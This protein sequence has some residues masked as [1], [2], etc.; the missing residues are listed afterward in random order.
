M[1]NLISVRS[2]EDSLINLSIIYIRS[3]SMRL[4]LRSFYLLSRRN[5]PIINM[6]M[7]D[8][9][10]L[11]KHI[12]QNKKVTAGRMSL[13]MKKVR[14]Y[15]SSVMERANLLRILKSVIKCYRY[16]GVKN[17]LMKV[18]LFMIIKVLKLLKLHVISLLIHLSNSTMKPTKLN[19][20]KYS[21]ALLNQSQIMGQV[22]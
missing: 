6:H 7:S 1:Q 20:F 18:Y 16:L 4:M 19:Q 12:D 22:N 21:T 15:Y 5:Q 13:I 2:A 14:F 8:A 10:I 9:I 3:F 17:K 11:V